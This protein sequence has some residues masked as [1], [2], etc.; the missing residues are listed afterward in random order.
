MDVVFGLVNSVFNLPDGLMKFF[1]GNS[2]T[3]KPLSI[4]VIINFPRAR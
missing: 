1:W 4:L 2:N 3:E